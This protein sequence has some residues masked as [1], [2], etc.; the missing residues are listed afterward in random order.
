[1]NMNEREFRPMSLL[2]CERLATQEGFDKMKFTALFPVG[3][4]KCQWLDAYMGI[5][6]VDGLEGFLMTGDIHEQFPDLL[7]IPLPM[8]A[9]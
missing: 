7:V 9:A 2:E 8:E 3:P 4:R 6:Q 5:F 1:M